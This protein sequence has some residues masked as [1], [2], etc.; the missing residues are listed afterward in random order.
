MALPPLLL[1]RL[2]ALR[3]RRPPTLPGLDETHL[4]QVEDEN[5]NNVSCEASSKTGP[6]SDS[7]PPPSAAIGPVWV[8]VKVR[9]GSPP[10]SSPDFLYVYNVCQNCSHTPEGVGG[11]KK[12]DV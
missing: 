2:G 7:L 12:G 8:G 3:A 11:L 5:M 10:S 6:V 9:Y 1:P 4:P